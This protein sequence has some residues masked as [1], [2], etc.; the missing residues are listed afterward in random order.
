MQYAK[1]A[2]VPK[3]FKDT[4]TEERRARLLERFPNMTILINPNLPP[5]MLELAHHVED[6]AWRIAAG[7]GEG[8]LSGAQATIAIHRL[9]E[10]KDYGCT[11]IFSR[12]DPT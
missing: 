2:E 4:L 6:V 11:S 8:R 10:A 12:D 5:E 7:A 9:R 1:K 3:R